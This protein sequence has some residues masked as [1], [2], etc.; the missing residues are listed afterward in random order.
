MHLM[1]VY[2]LGVHLRNVHLIDVPL[3][4][5]FLAGVY[6]INMNL[7][8]VH[9]LQGVHL[10]KVYISYRC[11]SLKRPSRRCASHGRVS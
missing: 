11:A 4:R 9:L 1:S 2:L 10:L 7:I 3:S 5:A 8:D 6:P